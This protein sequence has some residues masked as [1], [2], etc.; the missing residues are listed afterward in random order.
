[1]RV[2]DVDAAAAKAVANGG[3]QLSPALDITPGRMCTIASPG[4]APL[5]LFHEADEHAEHD[6]GGV[7]GVHWNDLHSHRAPDDM[8][9]LV[10]TFGYD[11][12]DMQM[13]DGAY[14]V[15][16]MGDQARGGVMASQHLDAPSMWL[17]W[18]NVADIDAALERVIANGG[19]VLSAAFDVPG[20]GRMGIAADSTGATIGLITPS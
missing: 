20:V 12:E 16:K 18:F 5:T 9:W 10:K 14:T 6:P 17:T 3:V 19:N 1:M 13:P 11:T 15:F 7:G 2:D 8:A 4:G